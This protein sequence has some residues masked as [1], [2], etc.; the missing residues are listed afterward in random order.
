M[1]GLDLDAFAGG[2]FPAS[3]QLGRSTSVNVASYWVGLGFTWHFDRLP[4]GDRSS[5]S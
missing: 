4:A 5:G 2:M 1:R 3:E